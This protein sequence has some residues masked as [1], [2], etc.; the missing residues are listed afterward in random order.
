MWCSSHISHRYASKSG[1]G[2]AK[3]RI[4][5]FN[6][7]FGPLDRLGNFYKRINTS[8]VDAER[9]LRLLDEPAEVNDKP[10]ASELSISEGEIEFG[11]FHK[12]T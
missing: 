2:V 11:E 3:A 7:L 1:A 8:M 10:D 5:I 4:L 9:L 12:V 6:Q